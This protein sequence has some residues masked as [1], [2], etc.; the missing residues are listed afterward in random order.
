MDERNDALRFLW[1]RLTPQT[2]GQYA[3]HFAKLRFIECGLDAYSAGP[4]DRAIDCL[5]RYAPGRCLE[6]CVKATRNRNRVFIEKAL[7]GTTPDRIATRLR[8]AFCV[9]FFLFEDGRE[10][11]MYLIPGDAWLEPNPCIVDSDDNDELGPCFEI[12]P[13]QNYESILDKY[14]FGRQ[15]LAG[16]IRK[17]QNPERA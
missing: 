15:L 9:A 14:R 16:I 17:A 7:V 13:L 2:L 4:N 1:S 11:E 10:P 8:Q 6:V 3:E 5:I 12:N